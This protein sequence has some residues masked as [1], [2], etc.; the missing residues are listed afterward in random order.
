[1]TF[2]FEHVLGPSCCGNL[3][4]ESCLAFVSEKELKRKHG[5]LFVTETYMLLFNAMSLLVAAL[6]S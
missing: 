6:E 4:C 3:S 1:M 5:S 2:G